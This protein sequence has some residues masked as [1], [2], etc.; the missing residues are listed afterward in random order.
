[1]KTR[2]NFC[3]YLVFAIS[4]HVANLH[5][6]QNSVTQFPALFCAVS[7]ALAATISYKSNSNHV[8]HRELSI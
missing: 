7:S 4:F 1:M 3:P 2:C 5:C 6:V 8:I